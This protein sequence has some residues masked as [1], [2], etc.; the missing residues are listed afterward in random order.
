LT[1]ALDQN[2]RWFSEDD[3]LPVSAL[4]HLVFCERQCALIYLEQ[5]WRDNPLTIEGSHRHNRAHE[6]APRRELRGELLIARGLPLHSFRLGLVGIA[7]VVEFHR[8][9]PDQGSILPSG[10]LPS[11]IPVRGVRGVWTPFPVEYK[12]GKPKPDSCDEVQLCAQAFCLQEMLGGAVTC[13]AMFYGKTQRRHNVDFTISLRQ[14]T[15][16]AASRL[17]ELFRNEITPPAHREAKCGSCSLLHV[18]RPEIL[19]PRRSARR[20]LVDEIAGSVENSDGG[21]R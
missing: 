15:E 1:K 16:A 17:H 2:G 12:R 18:C 3:L 5:T 20:Y 8:K 10:A 11:A 21:A 19:S 14:E 6:T 7:D 4:Q 9:A 13:G